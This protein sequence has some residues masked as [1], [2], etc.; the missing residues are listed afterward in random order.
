MNPLLI[1]R[2]Y[3]DINMQMGFLHCALCMDLSSPAL[4]INMDL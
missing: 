2:V 3:V 1:E 4:Y